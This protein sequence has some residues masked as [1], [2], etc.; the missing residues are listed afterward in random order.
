MVKKMKIYLFVLTECTKVTDTEREREREREREKDRHTDTAL[1]YRPR[2][3]SITRQKMH[4]CT[5]KLKKYPT[6]TKALVKK[7]I[8]RT[9]NQ[10]KP[11]PTVTCANCSYVCAYKIVVHGIAQNPDDLPSHPGDNHHSPDVYPSLTKTL[12]S[13]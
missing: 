8:K 4:K 10:P 6:Q 3:H 9:T 12:R 1:R 7:N 2:F 13:P 11:K 5:K